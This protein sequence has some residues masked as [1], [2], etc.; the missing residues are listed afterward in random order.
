VGDAGGLEAEPT[1]DPETELL[2]GSRGGNPP[3]KVEHFFIFTVNFLL[4]LLHINVVNMRK[5]QSACYAY[6][7]QSGMHP[8]I[9][10][11][12][13]PL[14]ITVEKRWIVV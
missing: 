4:T 10:F 8:L 12:I 14:A 3:P 2:V 9:L 7:C 13:L 6:R 11:W 1:A 5:S